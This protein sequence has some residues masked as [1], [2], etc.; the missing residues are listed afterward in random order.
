MKYPAAVG[1]MLNQRGWN[2]GLSRIAAIIG[3][4]FVWRSSITALWVT[5]LIACFARVTVTQVATPSP[6]SSRRPTC[7]QGDIGYFLSVDVGDYF[8]FIL[9]VM[10]LIAGAAQGKRT[11]ECLGKLCG[12]AYVLTSTVWL[13]F[14]RSRFSSALLAKGS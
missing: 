11:S 2:L 8:N 3:G 6:N 9:T 14:A 4:V 5:E 10:I 13:I 1:G 7:F 12:V